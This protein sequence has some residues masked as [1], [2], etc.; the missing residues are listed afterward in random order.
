MPSP[1]VRVNPVTLTCDPD[2]IVITQAN[3]QGVAIM[4]QIDPQAGPDWRW[5][6]TTTPI[7][8][9]APNGIFSDG[10]FPGGNGKGPVRLTNRNLPADVGTYKYTAT[11]IK[12]GD[13]SPTV[14]DPSIINRL[15]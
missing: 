1:V 2:S 13:A 15:T 8:V 7:V 3:G 9:Q 12:D 14:I 11:L 6:S 5:S 4:F 10:G